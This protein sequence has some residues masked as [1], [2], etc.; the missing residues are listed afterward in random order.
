MSIFPQWKELSQWN[1]TEVLY[2]IVAFLQ[3]IFNDTALSVKGLWTSAG[4]SSDALP[5][6]ATPKIAKCTG[7]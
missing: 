2:G 6:L 3:P 5:G 1:L 4:K 7:E